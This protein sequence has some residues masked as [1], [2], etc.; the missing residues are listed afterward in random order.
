MI[1]THRPRSQ[2]N[3][4]NARSCDVVDAVEVSLVATICEQYGIDEATRVRAKWRYGSAY[5]SGAVNRRRLAM[6][7]SRSGAQTRR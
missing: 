5:L 7:Q 3:A 4:R 6:G 1:S 2:N